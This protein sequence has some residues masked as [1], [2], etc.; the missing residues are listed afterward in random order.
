MA[1]RFKSSRW[2]F[3]TSFPGCLGVRPLVDNTDAVS[4][5]D[6]DPTETD[7]IRSAHEVAAYE[8]E[9][10][11]TSPGSSAAPPHCS[12]LSPLSRGTRG[13]TNGDME[14][15]STS[16]HKGEVGTL[17]SG[18]VALEDLREAKVSGALKST[19][20]CDLVGPIVSKF[21]GSKELTSTKEQDTSVSSETCSMGKRLCT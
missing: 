5:R 10:Q 7:N 14:S 3:V 16:P 17:R 20:P 1:A 13:A 12:Q 18:V 9:S 8:S 11:P 19:V 15:A 2:R 4:A 6:T 21:I